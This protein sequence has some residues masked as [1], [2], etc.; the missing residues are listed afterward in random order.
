MSS[1]LLNENLSSR[2]ETTSSYQLLVRD[3]PQASKTTL[4]LAIATAIA[5]ATATA[6]TI[7]LSLFWL[8]LPK[9]KI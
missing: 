5:T 9:K 6:T 1:E 4:A 3:A 8:E 7:H 2:H